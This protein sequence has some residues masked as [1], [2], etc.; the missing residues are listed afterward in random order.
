MAQPFDKVNLVFLLDWNI[1]LLIFV[2]GEWTLR[3]SQT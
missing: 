1:D 3:E 2:Q